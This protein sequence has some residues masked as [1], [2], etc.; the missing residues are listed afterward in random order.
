VLT[1]ITR[2]EPSFY[3]TISLLFSV[4]CFSAVILASSF[5][6][7][8][9]TAHFIRTGTPPLPAFNHLTK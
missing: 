7:L 2:L 3:T 4:Y 1:V 8:D 5:A 6:S 9:L